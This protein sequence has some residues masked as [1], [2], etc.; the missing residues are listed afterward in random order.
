MPGY[1][2]KQE[3][4]AIAGTD[5]LIIRSL[6]DR[7][8]FS[9]PDGVAEGLGISS[10]AWPLF[11]L[12]WPS[13]RHLAA[14]LAARSI[15]PGERV[16]ELGCGLALASLVAHRRGIDVTASDC[17]P[18]AAAFLRENLRLNQLPGMKYLHGQ[19]GSGRVVATQTAGAAALGRFDLVIGSDVLYER[20]E[21]GDL[22]AFIA[23]RCEPNAEVCIVDPNRGN[24]PAFNRCMAAL[25][26]ALHEVQL[27]V[28]LAPGVPAYRG[29]MLHYHRRAAVWH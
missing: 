15:V 25:G 14:G 23:A 6:L 13:G 9:D 24:R 19:W 8:Q 26:F 1:L 20:D 21:R 5:D 16:L 18:L 3:R 12:L 27:N 4:I 28:P 10:A 11:G 2:V 7:Q 22:A 29:R 17:H